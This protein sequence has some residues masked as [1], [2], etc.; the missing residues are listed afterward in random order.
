MPNITIFRSAKT[1]RFVTEAYA[2]SHKAT[3]VKEIINPV[4]ANPKKQ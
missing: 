1:G 3:T 4:K 2:K